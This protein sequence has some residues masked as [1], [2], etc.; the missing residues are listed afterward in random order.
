[1]SS[2]PPFPPSRLGQCAP[3]TSYVD[4]A[5]FEKE[6]AGEWSHASLVGGDRVGVAGSLEGCRTGAQAGPDAILSEVRVTGM[7]RP[8]SSLPCSTGEYDVMSMY[9]DVT[10]IQ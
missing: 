7:A 2:T 9:D 6:D 1:M 5:L 3:P 10:C 4:D 8:D